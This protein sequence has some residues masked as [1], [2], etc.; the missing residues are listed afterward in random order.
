MAQKKLS[1]DMEEYISKIIQQSTRKV[2]RVRF[3]QYA[4]LSQEIKA[5]ITKKKN[6]I[7]R[8]S[9]HMKNP[10][11]RRIAYLMTCQVKEVL[12]NHFTEI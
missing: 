3:S 2:T 12:S 7:G 4:N 9:Q 8:I 10:E 1:H 11:I 6:S 5:Q